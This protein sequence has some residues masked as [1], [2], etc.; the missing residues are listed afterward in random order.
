MLKRQKT[1]YKLSKLGKERLTKAH[2][3][4]QV[5]VNEMLWYM[6]F[7]LIESVRSLE[8]QKANLAKGVSKTLKSKHLARPDG[9]SRAIDIWPYPAPRNSKGEL[10]SN[11]REWDKL[12]MVAFYCAGKLGFES[13]EW[14]GLWKSLVDKPHYEMEE[15]DV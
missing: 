15:T 9:Y 5:L 12:A 7:S 2:P 14:G 13:L 11:S 6:D 10:D 3:K 1:P 4:L 8:Q